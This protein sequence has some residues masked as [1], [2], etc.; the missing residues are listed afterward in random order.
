MDPVSPVVIAALLLDAEPRTLLAS[1]G[2]DTPWYLLYPL[3]LSSRRGFRSALR[4]GE[5]PLPPRWLREIHYATHSLLVLGIWLGVRGP[6]KRR[7]NRIAR[8][9]GLHILLDMLTH[10]R[11]RM[12]SPVFWPLSRW[13][14]DGL[15]WADQAAAAIAALLRRRPF[16][17][18]TPLD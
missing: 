3:W 6:R 2:P 16:D 10:S 9:W 12:A 1:L 13:A 15:S 8:A 5:W 14:Y 11:R 7:D 4:T 17:L 18:L